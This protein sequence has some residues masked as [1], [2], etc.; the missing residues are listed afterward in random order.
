MHRARM[1][2]DG[3]K[4]GDRGNKTLGHDVVRLLKTQDAGYLRIMAQKARKDAEMTRQEIHL[5]SLLEDPE[6]DH[7]GVDDVMTMRREVAANHIVYVDS[8]QEQKTFVPEQWFHTDRQGLGRTFNRPRIS[9][10]PPSSSANEAKGILSKS[11]MT[12]DDDDGVSNRQ[13]GRGRRSAALDRWKKR[14]HLLQ[15]RQRQLELAED[16]LCLQRAH[17]TKTPPVLS[18]RGGS[19]RGTGSNSS[20]Q[21]KWKVRERKR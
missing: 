6:R 5:D 4:L 18:R 1:A 12:N 16:Q 21:R 17:M 14:L 9:L 11:N 13:R 8:K 10:P 2:K 7:D 19:V 3:T 15:T 20:Q